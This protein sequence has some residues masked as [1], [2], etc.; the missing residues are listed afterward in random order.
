[1][2]EP[3]LTPT[4]RMCLAA[5]RERPGTPANELPGGIRTVLA[6]MRRELVERAPHDAGGPPAWLI[7]E[8]QH[9]HTFKS[10]MH[11][12]GCHWWSSAGACSCGATIAVR[13]ERNPRSDPYSL[14]WMDP[15]GEGCACLRCEA[16]TR[17]ARIAPMAVELVGPRRRLEAVA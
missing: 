15:A 14:V 5:V 6:L 9:R 16:I 4:Q 7:F 8:P 2:S 10:T 13:G 17:G 11:M 12:D 3:E 1:M